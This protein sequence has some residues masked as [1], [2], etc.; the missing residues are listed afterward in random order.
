MNSRR[1][2]TPLTIGTFII[3]SITGALMFFEVA[4]GSIRATHEWVSLLFV[5]AALLHIYTNK[6]P[7]IR[8]FSNRPLLII[9]ASI[10]GGLSLFALSFNDIYLAEA[11]FQLLTNLETSKLSLIL[12][13]SYEDLLSKLSTFGITEVNPEQSLYE[14][15]EIYEM[16]VHDIL[17]QLIQP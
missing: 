15:A 9:V 11:S 16:D 12:E 6:Q 2:Y 7:F 5:V 3:A 1:I 17:E 4:P 10:T 14:V 8:Y 13:I